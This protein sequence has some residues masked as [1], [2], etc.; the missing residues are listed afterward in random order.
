MSDKC[1]GFRSRIADS[2][3]GTLPE[4]DQREL[5]EHL[6]VC[7]PCRDYL[8]AL[9]R[10]DA[11]LAEYFAGIEEDMA[12]R[13]ERALQMIECFHTNAR[14][15]TIWRRIMKSRYS[16]LATAA[17]ILVLIAATL[18]VLDK[19]ASSAY[20]LDQTVEALRNVRFVHLIERDDAG[21]VRGERWIEI[22]E[23]G[24]QT[25]YRRDKPPHLFVIDDGKSIARYHP[26]AN[27]VVLRDPNEMRY[28]W[29]R[30]IGQAFEN[31]RD[32]GMVLEE[33]A[34]YHGRR[35]HKVWWPAMRG[36]CYVDP[37]TK[38]PIA[39]GNTE[40]SYEQPP[41]GIFDIVVPR[42]YAMV[43]AVDESGWRVG[44]ELIQPDGHLAEIVNA[45]DV[46]RLHRTGPHTYEGDL[47]LQVACSEDISW[48]LSIA[49]TNPPVR[50]SYSCSIDRFDM[51]KPGGVAT[52]GV[53]LT[54]EEI[55]E[56][57]QDGQIAAVRL[58]VEP[59]PAPMD[60]AWA[61]QAL[62]LALYDAKHYEG[63]LATFRR[64]E[65]QDNADPG[66]R[67]GAI[68]WQGHMLDL[69][70][71]RNEAIARY[72]AVVEMGLDSGTRFDSYGLAYKYTPYATERMTTPFTRVE[73]R[74]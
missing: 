21:I 14:P 23:D 7:P 18:I 43:D 5:Q 51:A 4:Q 40:L 19:S 64:M 71:R 11:S 65:Q 29:I 69:L 39:I 68:I 36:V 15:N 60:D 28:E 63:A 24:R 38:L 9:R 50:G 37:A 44:V 8:Q 1:H 58:R 67:A 17:A 72:K 49:V 27:A 53:K 22:G 33:N 42:G 52:V 20:A 30:P 74:L 3:A 35:A 10:E 70:G 56:T 16:K 6:S 61:L 13:Q 73:R 26:Y 55:V 45:E 47:D 34:N 32:E 31:A 57:P 66:C 59:R 2:L 62:G 25:R 54:A 41:V 48:G 12:D 46:I